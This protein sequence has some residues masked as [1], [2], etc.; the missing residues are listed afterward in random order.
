[1]PKANKSAERCLER[2]LDT[3][4]IVSVQR[5]DLAKI[6]AENS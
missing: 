1:M 2:A 5:I 6:C 3:V 4:W